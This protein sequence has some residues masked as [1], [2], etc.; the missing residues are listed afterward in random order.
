MD[1][2]KCL[3]S[4]EISIYSLLCFACVFLFSFDTTPLSPF[5]RWLF[6]W[7]FF[8]AFLAVSLC[9][10][11]SL[12]SISLSL[13]WLGRAAS[14]FFGERV[15]GGFFSSTHTLFLLEVALR[16]RLYGCGLCCV[17]YHD[18]DI[19]QHDAILIPH[20]EKETVEGVG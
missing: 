15:K 6:L 5:L 18:I 13:S 14:V 11:P 9:S 7:A 12:P 3:R 17:V 19:L 8:L 10:P 20:G 2:K 16:G 1:K 4:F